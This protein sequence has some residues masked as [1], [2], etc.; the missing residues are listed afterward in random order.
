M[1]AERSEDIPIP[2]GYEYAPLR[3]LSNEGRDKLGRVRPVSL[4]QA[5]RIPGV[6]P[7]DIAML[8]VHLAQGRRRQAA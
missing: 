1:A 2:D 7:A 5:A 3:A 8:S 6:T 4:G